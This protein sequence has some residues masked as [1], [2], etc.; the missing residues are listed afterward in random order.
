MKFFYL[1]IVSFVFIAALTLATSVGSFC[2]KELPYNNNTVPQVQ[3]YKTGPPL[4]QLTGEESFPDISSYAVLAT[5]L[6]SEVTLYQKNSDTKLLPAST[7][8]IVTALVAMD[9]Y[10]LDRILTVPD[11]YI[12]GQKMH[13]VPGEEIS[14]RNL[15][16]G[17][18]VYS[19]NDAA[20]TLAINYPGGKESFVTAMNLKIQDLGINNTFFENPSG[21][22][23][24]LQYT[25]ASDLV[26]IASFALQDPFF[27]EVVAT[28]E[29]TVGSQ[30]GHYVHRL[31]NINKLVGEVEGVLGIKTGWTENAR[32]NLVT[33]V[34]RDGRKIITVV[35]NSQDRFGDTKAL[36]DWIFTNYT[37][38]EIGY[39]L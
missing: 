14:V 26:K 5:D 34:E 18:L 20:E 12:E 21:F 30:D 9:Y 39:S 2:P 38:K 4:P 32:E 7:T 31:T 27:R 23:G 13:L 33:Y 8:K 19:A 3:A 36:I 16:Y 11:N 37:W 10:P 17:I 25:T 35:L 22:D 1:S 24:E 29:I 6:D 15:I 28:K